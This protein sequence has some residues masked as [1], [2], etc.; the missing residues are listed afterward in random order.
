MQEPGRMVRPYTVTGGRTRPARD[1]LAPETLLVTTPIGAA[2]VDKL[3]FEARLIAE[4]CVDARSVAEIA[5]RLAVPLGVARV[6]ISDLANDHYVTIHTGNTNGER[7]DK[8]MLERLLDG[9]RAL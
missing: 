2:A 4:H 9:L 3:R 1:D 8:A 6:L 5:S 7:P